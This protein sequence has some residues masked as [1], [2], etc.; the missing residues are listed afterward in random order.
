M[1]QLNTFLF[2]HLLGETFGGTKASAGLLKKIISAFQ[3]TIG[4]AHFVFLWDFIKS[5]RRKYFRRAFFAL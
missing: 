4:V 3:V 1:G 2:V 5:P